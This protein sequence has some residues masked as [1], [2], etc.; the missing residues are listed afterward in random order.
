MYWWLK[1]SGKWGFHGTATPADL[2]AFFIS[3]LSRRAVEKIS[4]IF[5]KSNL[6]CFP[7][8]ESRMVWSIIREG[9]KS[10]C[11]CMSMSTS[12]S[13]SGKGAHMV[14]RG[15][16]STRSVAMIV[17]RVVLAWKEELILVTRSGG[18]DHQSLSRLGA[19][20]VEPGPCWPWRARQPGMERLIT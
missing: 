20:G 11:T 8:K 14:E 12:S 3:V 13:G 16:A 4:Y 10:V 7:L 2:L 5:C 18:T 19:C 17:D 15:F 1:I 6:T 9:F